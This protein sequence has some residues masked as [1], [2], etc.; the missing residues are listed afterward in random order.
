M[1]AQDEVAVGWVKA[2]EI[3]KGQDHLGSVAPCIAIYSALLPG[4]TNVTDRARYYSFYPWFLWKYGQ[5]GEPLES[6]RFHELFRRADCLFTL[7]AEHHGMESADNSGSHGGGMVGGRKLIPAVSALTGNKTLKL[8]TFAT[9]ED[10]PARYFQNRLGGLGQYYLGTLEGLG[11]L[12]GRNND[13]V[14]YDGTFGREI[15]QHFDAGVPANEFWATLTKD[16]ISAKVLSAL[17]AFCPC[18]LSKNAPEH[19]WL[20][21]LF[22]GRSSDLDTSTERRR[23]SLGLILHLTRETATDPDAAAIDVDAF[24][25]ACYSKTL[26]NGQV[27]TIPESLLEIRDHWALYQRNEILSI[28]VQALLSVFVRALELMANAPAT[29]HG[30]ARFLLTAPKLRRI[31]K[32]SWVQFLA[33]RKK[34]LPPLNDFQGPTHELRLIKGLLE[35]KT[36]ASQLSELASTLQDILSIVAA[37][38]L[39]TAASGGPPYS[40]LPITETFLTDYP[41][42]LATFE[43]TK[44]L[45]RGMDV[46]QVVEWLMHEWACETHLRIALGKLRMEHNDTFRFYPTESGLKPYQVPPFAH[47]NPRVRNALQILRDIGALKADTNGRPQVTPRGR[48]WLEEV[49]RS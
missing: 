12:T 26:P 16:T 36:A 37:L 19:S 48:I 14:Q 39:R 45:W 4:M 46:G 42:N 22:L 17:T 33:D 28:S 10:E 49:C 41:I 32:I 2:V 38:I 11:I 6:T 31:A 15:A 13:F 18:Q 21:D 9:Q 40:D 43:H 47:S 25:N 27:W 3:A 7:I 24:R 35:L 23:R 29:A 30:V 5:S 20:A 8:S 44:A 1:P 34:T